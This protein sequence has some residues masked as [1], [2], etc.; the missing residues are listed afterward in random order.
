MFVSYILNNQAFFAVKS[1]LLNFKTY[2]IRI[3][4]S[5]ISGKRSKPQSFTQFPIAQL[6]AQTNK[7]AEH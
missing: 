4:I 5:L 7:K 1:L 6:H 2:S 3:P